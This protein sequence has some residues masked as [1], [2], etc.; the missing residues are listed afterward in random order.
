M[1]AVGEFGSLNLDQ[2]RPINEV[3][4]GY[5]YFAE[6]DLCIAKIT[7]C[8]ENGKGALATNLTNGVGFGTT[9]LH[10]IRTTGT[11]DARFLYYI[12]IAHD[13]RGFGA[14]EMLGAGGQKRVPEAFIK[15][16]RAPLPRIETQQRIAAFLDKKTAQIDALIA[17]KQALLDR[18]AEK[19]QAIITQAVTK[20]LNPTAPMKDSGINW[21]GQIPAHWKLL[22]LRRVASQ[23]VTGPTPPSAAGDFFTD[24]EVPW[25]TPGDF[26]GDILLGSTEKRLT[27]DAF[28][29][30]HAVLYPPD[31]V[32]LVGIGA[33]LGKVGL[34][35]MECSSNQQINAITVLPENDPVFLAYFLHGFRAEVRISA[36]GNTLPILNQDKTKMQIVTC[37]PLKEQSLIGAYL[38]KSDQKIDCVEIRIRESI[39]LLGERRSAVITQAVTGKTEIS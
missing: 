9:E 31:S 23:V 32:L 27:R 26:S 4:T 2:V 30:G 8:F 1:E 12:S 35:T 17:K 37:P 24:G 5:T 18:L 15:N 39:S 21:L 10:V 29:E 3:Y 7:P 34:A 25:F 28:Q 16:W 14:S 19:R 6:G 22:P 38:R 33:T 13:F 36:S 11:L 20:G